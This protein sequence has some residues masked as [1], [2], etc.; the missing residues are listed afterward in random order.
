MNRLAFAVL[1]FALAACGRAR[2]PAGP[3]ADEL[4]AEA[5]TFVQVLVP[6]SAQTLAGFE[7][8]VARLGDASS[9]TPA[10]FKQTYELESFSVNG[11]ETRVMIAYTNPWLAPATTLHRPMTVPQFLRACEAEGRDAALVAP[12]GQIYIP[13]AQMPDVRAKLVL[14]G[15]SDKDM[16][17]VFIRGSLR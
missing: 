9:V 3:T 5:A 14:L 11:Q 7:E 6:L 13:R 2:P 4:G 15:A 8:A 12:K 10:D 17:L 1:A 16:P